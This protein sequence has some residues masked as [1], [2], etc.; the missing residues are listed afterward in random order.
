MQPGPSIGFLIFARAIGTW[1]AVVGVSM[2]FGPLVGGFL[3]QSV[4][5]RSVFVINI[6]IGVAAIVLTALFVP[7]SRAAKARSFDPL[8]LAIAALGIASTTSWARA[9]TARISHLLEEPTP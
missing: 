5:W 1:G 4:G 6:P 9:S 8:G 3:T 2:G 7:E